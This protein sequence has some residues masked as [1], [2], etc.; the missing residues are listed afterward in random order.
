LT[1]IDKEGFGERLLDLQGF[2]CVR[3][4]CTVGQSLTVGVIIAR[5]LVSEM[6]EGMMRFLVISRLVGISVTLGL[7]GKFVIPGGVPVSGGTVGV[8]RK[9]VSGA[10]SR[11]V[12]V[13]T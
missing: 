8:E 1:G 4:R 11:E 9:G 5:F 6:T 2:V 3:S 7:K 10:T 12:R 13:G